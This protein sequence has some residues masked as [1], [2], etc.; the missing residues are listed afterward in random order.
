M[1]CDMTYMTCDNTYM[2][3]D[4]TYMTCDMTDMTCDMLYTLVFGWPKVSIFAL[5]K[6][7]VVP[8]SPIKFG[9]YLQSSAGFAPIIDYKKTL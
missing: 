5:S 6:F 9:K 1:T 2:T 4:I 3:C 8:D 7:R